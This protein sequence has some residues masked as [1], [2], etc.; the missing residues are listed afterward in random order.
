MFVSQKKKKMF[1]I[2]VKSLPQVTR[3]LQYG[4]VSS[5]AKENKGGYG[6]PEEVPN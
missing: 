4:T 5:T 6:F 2:I 3:K 1:C